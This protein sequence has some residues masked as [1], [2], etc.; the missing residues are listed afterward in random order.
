MEEVVREGVLGEAR[1]HRA[2]DAQA[3]GHGAHVREAALAVAPEGPG[4]GEHAAH[5]VELGP[6]DLHPDRPAVLA[7]E[8][9]LGVEG[10]DLGGPAVHVQED[11]ALGPGRVVERVERGAGTEPSLPAR[12]GGRRARPVAAVREQRGER[13]GAEALGPAEQELAAAEPARAVE[14]AAEEGVSGGRRA[15]GR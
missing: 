5:V 14:R 10:V 2:H 6:R 1:G 8:A 12:G 7:L 4:R 3:V 13:Q 11:H 9:R 15:H